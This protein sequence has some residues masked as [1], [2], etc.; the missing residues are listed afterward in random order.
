MWKAWWLALKTGV[1]QWREMVAYFGLE[2]E[3]SHYVLIGHTVQPANV[4]SFFLIKMLCV[5]VFTS[6]PLTTVWAL[7]S[8]A[9]SSR[10]SVLLS[11]NLLSWST[12]IKLL[13]SWCVSQTLQHPGLVCLSLFFGSVC[14]LERNHQICVFCP[15]VSSTFPAEFDIVSCY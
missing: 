8:M 13:Q 9:R 6:P 4:Y 11:S 7:W 12:E 2:E 5:D 15:N 14:R 1:N 10:K 3:S